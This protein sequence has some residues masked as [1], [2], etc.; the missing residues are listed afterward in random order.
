MSAV[1]P[2]SPAS[3]KGLRRG[4]VILEVNQQPVPDVRAF[5]KASKNDPKGVLLLVRRGEAEIFVALKRDN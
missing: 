4:D 2:E 5:N 3:E 1:E